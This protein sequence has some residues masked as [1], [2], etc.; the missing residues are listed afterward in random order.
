FRSNFQGFAASR[1]ARE[2]QFSY[3]AFGAEPFRFDLANRRLAAGS[4]AS[5]DA[6]RM[7]GLD[8]RD[9]KNSTQPT[10]AGRKLA[11]DPYERSRAYALAPDAKRFALGADLTFD[12]AQ[13]LGSSAVL[14]MPGIRRIT[15][16]GFVHTLAGRNFSTQQVLGLGGPAAYAVFG[17]GSI[18]NIQSVARSPDGHVISALI[19]G[20]QGAGALISVEPELPGLSDDLTQ[21]VSSTDGREVYVFDQVGRHLETRDARFGNVTLS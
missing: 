2:V 11:L 13:Q 3:A 6:A 8:L 12:V 9:W 5:L 17:H 4:N 20:S 1:D 18:G 15:S 21:Q 10:L 16:D 19:A 7:S 14:G